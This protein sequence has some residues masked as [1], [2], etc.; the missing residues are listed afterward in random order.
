M[1]LSCG[2]RPIGQS[3][4]INGYAVEPIELIG[5]CPVGKLWPDVLEK[6]P[7]SEEASRA[8]PVLD[9]FSTKRHDVYWTPKPTPGKT[10]DST[11]RQDGCTW[12]EVDESAGAALVIP[13]KDAAPFCVVGDASG[14]RHDFTRLEEYTF[15]PHK[16]NQWGSCSWVNWPI[17]WVNAVV[18]ELD[19][20]SLKQY[21]NV[22]CPA[23][24]DFHYHL[25]PHSIDEQGVYY[26]LIGVGDNNNLEA[27]RTVARR[28]LEKGTAAII[29]PDSTADLPGPGIN[30]KQ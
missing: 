24:V 22:F 21:P 2:G 3:F 13:L 12:K 30:H 28:W 11:H 27:I 17:G 26:S 5:L 14:F 6:D 29:Q 18:H 23:G 25:I 7:A 19:A 8:W 15:N 4:P 1:A 16:G 10:W 9:A 20:E